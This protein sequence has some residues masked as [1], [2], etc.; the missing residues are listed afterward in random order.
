MDRAWASAEAWIAL[1]LLL[2]MLLVAAFAA[3]VRVLMHF[4]VAWAAALLTG[5]LAWTDT[6]LRTGTLW[7]AFLGMSLAAYHQR[8]VRVETVLRRA[9]PLSR[10]KLLAAASL[11][12]SAICVGLLIAFSHAVAANLAERPAE[13]ELLDPQGQALH[14]CDASA[15]QLAQVADLTRPAVFCAVRSVLALAGLRAETPRAAFQLIVPLMLLVTALRFLGHGAR[16]M[17]LASAGDGHGRGDGGNGLPR[18]AP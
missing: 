9:P 6:L 5:D 17:R 3:V 12:T 10:A 11:A 2:S 1:G 13:Y 7:L 18:G 16:Q 8:H 14:L 15:A 4:E